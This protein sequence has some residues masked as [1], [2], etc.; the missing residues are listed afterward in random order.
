MKMTGQT[1]LKD[2]LIV[3][4]QPDTPDAS[5]LVSEL[6]AYLM[7]QYPPA[8]HHGMTVERLLAERVDFFVLR[9]GGAAAGC[10]GIQNIQ[11][12]YGE[13]KRF[14]VR[15]EFRRKGLGKILLRHLEEFARAQGFP[16]V[17]L[18]TGVYQLEA[19]NLYESSGYRR[20]P[21]FGPYAEDP[22]SLFYEKNLA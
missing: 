22:L 2:V 17:R 15:P 9:C 11:G 5:A 21:P 13:L 6:D 16:I 3:R 7:P 10:C 18:E 19:M 14:Y 1:A 8:S 4:E 12:E 20:I